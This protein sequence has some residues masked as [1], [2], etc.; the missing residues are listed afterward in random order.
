MNIVSSAGIS[1]ALAGICL[2]RLLKQ[3]SALQ[4]PDFL[5]GFPPLRGG[6]RSLSVGAECIATEYRALSELLA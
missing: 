2:D 6:L 3:R 5:F 4:K 1:I